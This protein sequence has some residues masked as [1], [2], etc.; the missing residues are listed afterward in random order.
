MNIELNVMNRKFNREF[1]R[2][3][4]QSSTVAQIRGRGTKEEITLE[5]LEKH[6]YRNGTRIHITP[7]E[8]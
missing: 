5:Q 4:C 7:V 8:K 6:I 3:N 2:R 1:M